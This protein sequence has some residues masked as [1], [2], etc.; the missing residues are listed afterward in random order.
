MVADAYV[1]LGG[2]RFH[3][4]EWG[5]KGQ[6][7][8]LLHGL[9]STCHIWDLTAPLLQKEFR[10][11]ALDQRGHG[12]S[13]KPDDSDY[14]FATIVGDLKGFCGALDLRRPVVVGHSWGASVALQYA[15]DFPSEAAGL[16]MV[17]GGF[18]EI[19]SRL[20][21]E[22]AEK[23]LTPPQLDGV[24][25]HEFLE[26]AQT[27]PGIGDIWSP[28]VEQII[29]ANFEISPEETI[30]PRLRRANHMKIVRALYDQKASQLY[31]LVNCPVLAAPARRQP[32]NEREES[33]LN[34]KINGIKAMQER[35]NHR[36]KVEWMED[37]IHD[38]PVQMPQRLATAINAFVAEL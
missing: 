29:L 34:H 22:E 18:A 16:V 26:K 11:L 3:Y 36:L 38:V 15:A 32:Q 25:L 8:V 13:D 14:D 30:R 2:L 37:S 20:S 12:R 1:A 6:A 33:F 7:V 31:G 27:W 24:P 28:D 23:L 4:R 17:D 5:G 35:L 19:S 9:A 21:W 10:V